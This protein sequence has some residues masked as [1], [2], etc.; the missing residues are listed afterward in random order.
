MV[1]LADILLNGFHVFAAAGVLLLGHL[2]AQRLAQGVQ[3][4]K[5]GFAI[6]F[7]VK[8]QFVQRHQ[9]SVFFHYNAGL[10][11]KDFHN[12]AVQLAHAAAVQTAAHKVFRLQKAQHIFHSFGIACAQA[13]GQ[14]L[15][16]YIGEVIAIAG[17]KLA[18]V[19]LHRCSAVRI[20]LGGCGFL[21]A[22]PEL[23]QVIAGGANAPMGFHM[24]LLMQPRRNAVQHAQQFFL[25]LDLKHIQGFQGIALVVVHRAHA[26]LVH[27]G[28][29]GLLQHLGVLHGLA[30][31][32]V[33]I[34]TGE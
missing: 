20:V 1:V 4:L 13:L 15:F 21:G 9:V 26:Q 30:V 28:A 10:C 16:H 18:A 32:G 24:V 14:P 27:I 2:A 23:H 31:N 33:N 6:A 25:V 17:A 22:F 11:G 29:D 5:I 3:P 19:H 34:N 8:R 7:I 12:A